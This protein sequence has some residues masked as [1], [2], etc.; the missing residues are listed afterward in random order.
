M[1]NILF[2]ISE[3]GN[4]NVDPVSLTCINEFLLPKCTTHTHVYL[5]EREGC[6]T[7][8]ISDVY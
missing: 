7:M 2:K 3:K 8:C 4:I 1:Y 5:R 6:I